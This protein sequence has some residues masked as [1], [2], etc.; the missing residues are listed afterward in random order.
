MVHKVDLL[1]ELYPAPQAAIYFV[2]TAS[3]HVEPFGDVDKLDLGGTLHLEHVE[4]V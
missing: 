3:F 1:L 4:V 2:E